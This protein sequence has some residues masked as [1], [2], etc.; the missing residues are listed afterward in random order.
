MKEM[1]TVIEEYKK[2]LSSA[3]IQIYRRRQ[4]ERDV[5]RKKANMPAVWKELAT[6]WLDKKYPGQNMTEKVMAE[7]DK[8]AGGEA[9]GT[10]LR[11]LGQRGRAVSNRKKSRSPLP[12]QPGGEGIAWREGAWVA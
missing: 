3:G 10:G 12:G 11:D 8:I 7:L 9:L 4:A 5:F 6:P 2:K 1:Q